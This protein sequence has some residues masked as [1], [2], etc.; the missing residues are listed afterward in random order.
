MPERLF[1]CL[2]GLKA[3]RWRTPHTMGCSPLRANRLLLGG[4][5]VGQLARAAPA[6]LA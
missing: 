2:A 3:A 1:F 6:P 4:L 5:R